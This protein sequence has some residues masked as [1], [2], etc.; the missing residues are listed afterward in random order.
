[1]HGERRSDGQVGE[2]FEAERA[3]QPHDAHAGQFGGRPQRDLRAL[4][5]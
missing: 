4:L 3:V 5:S 1:V 2:G